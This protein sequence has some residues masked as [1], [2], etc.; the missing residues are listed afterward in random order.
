MK[1]LRTHK[2]FVLCIRTKGDV[3]LEPRKVYEVLTDR[4]A[5][6]DGYL[7]VVDESGEDYLY[8][9]AYFVPVRLPVA[10]M[11]DFEAFDAAKGPANMALQPTGGAAQRAR[12]ARLHAARG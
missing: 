4:A 5:S 2:K 12:R 11:R 7:R 9:A 6:R 10:A 3:D 8:P 1:R